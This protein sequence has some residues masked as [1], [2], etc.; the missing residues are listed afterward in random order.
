MK[1]YE[2]RQIDLGYG[3]D[4][5]YFQL[6]FDAIRNVDSKYLKYSINGG[7]PCNHVERV[8]AYELY[9]Q[10]ANRIEPEFKNKLV[11]NAEL[12]KVIYEEIYIRKEDSFDKY[13]LTKYPDIV[14]HSS[15]GNDDS[16]IMICE[17]K[18][19]NVDNNLILADLYKLC[20]YMDRDKFNTAR[21]PFQYGVFIWVNGDLEKLNF[22]KDNAF[23][24]VSRN[25]RGEE[26]NITCGDMLHDY[27]EHF[28][29]IIC[30]DYN[31]TLLRYETADNLLNLFTNSILKSKP[32]R[33][34]SN[35]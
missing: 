28:H 35:K 30:I 8:F 11:L 15:Q 1:I 26:K 24:V 13:E 5:M 2:G 32:A 9:R 27:H 29:N 17:I 25:N 22:H 20:C 4:N 31:G 7:N 33:K 10:W 12:G 16:Q 34:R 21:T 6:L 14:L 18:K 19:G 23:P 3:D